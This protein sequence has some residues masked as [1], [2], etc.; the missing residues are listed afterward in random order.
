MADTIFQEAKG[1]CEPE[2]TDGPGLENAIQRYQAAL[3][4]SDQTDLADIQTKVAF[5]LG[6]AYSC[7]SLAQLADRWS[8][9]ESNTRFVIQE[10][11]KGN[12]RIKNLA[13]EAHANLGILYWT[14]PAQGKQTKDNDLQLAAAE[15]QA[16]LELASSQGRKSLFYCYLAQL[17]ED[18]QEYDRADEAWQFAIQLETHA[19]PV[20]YEM[21]EQF[22]KN[23]QILSSDD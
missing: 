21:Q 22:Q 14:R 7:Q 23:R 13:S 12:H 10:F 18:L 19:T 17:Y 5:Y 8:E 1:N 11:E 3:T 2:S 9:A 20:Y 15:F 6:R 16:A 4:A